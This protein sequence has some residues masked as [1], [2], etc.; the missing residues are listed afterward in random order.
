M[1]LYVNSRFSERSP[2][3]AQALMAVNITT[4]IRQRLSSPDP[5]LQARCAELASVFASDRRA[6]AALRDSNSVA[7][8]AECLFSAN[9]ATSAN[10][11]ATLSRLL[12]G[13][14]AQAAAAMGADLQAAG[15][16]LALINLLT[17]S[18]PAAP[19]AAQG[20][21]VGAQEQVRISHNS[22]YLF[23]LSVE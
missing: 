1:H 16:M 15:G 4:A 9:R 21:A 2:T 5:Q 23:W 8:L 18:S 17:S 22:L 3:H 10:A 13:A 12:G 7:A 14:D 6:Q 20:A 19:G 11:L